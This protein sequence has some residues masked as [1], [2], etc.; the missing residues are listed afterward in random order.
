[1]VGE[2]SF[3]QIRL[4]KV[5][6]VLNKQTHKALWALLIRPGDSQGER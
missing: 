5:V 1:M 2:Q 3:K 4:E 6:V